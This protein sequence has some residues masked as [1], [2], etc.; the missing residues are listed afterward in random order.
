MNYRQLGKMKDPALL[1]PE[2][3]PF[4]AVLFDLLHSVGHGIH[5]SVLKFSGSKKCELYSFLHWFDIPKWKVFFLNMET[6]YQAFY[7]NYSFPEVAPVYE[8]RAISIPEI[9]KTQSLLTFGARFLM[10][11]RCIRVWPQ[12]KVGDWQVED[13]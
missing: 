11:I 13:K 12:G 7:E 5:F 2:T 8:R 9:L 4:I 10:P 3:Y 6:N 1:F